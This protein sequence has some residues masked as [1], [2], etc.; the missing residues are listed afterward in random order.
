MSKLQGASKPRGSCHERALGLLAVR[1]RSRREL[2]QRLLR[3]GFDPQE[4]AD[5]LVRL[6]GVGLIDDEA[7]ARAVA[8]HGFGSRKQGV[9]AVRSALAAKGVAP[10]ITESVLEEALG[11]ELERALELAR[12]RASRLADLEARKAFQRLTGLLIR[13]G[14]APEVARRA[15]RSALDLDREMD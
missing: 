6:E 2:E 9:R 7:F 11:D 8:E 3:A 10:A 4:V 13:R 1:Q 14:Y 15:S 12:G 5:V